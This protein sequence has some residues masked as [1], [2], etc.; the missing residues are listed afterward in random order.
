MHVVI[1]IL[2]FV[3]DDV[4]DLLLLRLVTIEGEGG[5]E[6]DLA[7]RSDWLA[8]ARRCTRGISAYPPLSLYPAPFA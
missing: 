8:T 6:R 1:L 2:F 5:K 3:G 7:R 4:V